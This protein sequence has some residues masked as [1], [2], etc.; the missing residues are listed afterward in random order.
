MQREVVSHIH[1]CLDRP[2]L[3]S[4]ERRRLHFIRHDTGLPIS[5]AF[6]WRR[7]IELKWGFREFQEQFDL[8]FS[9]LKFLLNT[10]GIK[11]RSIREANSLRKVKLMREKTCISKF[12]VP[13]ASQAEIIKEKKRCTF[14]K[15]YGVDNIFKTREFVEWLPGEMHA[16]YG[17]GSLSGSGEWLRNR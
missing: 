16:R 11:G 9:E 15:N 14:I 10:F 6:I 13:N 7:Y 5:K 1:Y 3:W 12:G 8:A 2:K 17:K 4:N